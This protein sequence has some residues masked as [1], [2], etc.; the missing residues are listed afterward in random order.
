M[1]HHSYNSY[2]EYFVIIT[3]D[4]YDHVADYQF[5]LDKLQEFT[6]T[7]ITIASL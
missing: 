2:Y 5:Y 7:V 1:F 6:I 3:S 4:G